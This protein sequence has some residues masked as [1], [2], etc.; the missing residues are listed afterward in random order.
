MMYRLIADALEEEG[1][2]NV[3]PKDYLHFFC[4]GKREPMTPVSTMTNISKGFPA[5][6]FRCAWLFTA[7]TAMHVSA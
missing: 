2:T 5:T 1:I 6:F 4:L 7:F 3:Q